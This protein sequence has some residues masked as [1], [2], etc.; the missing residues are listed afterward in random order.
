MKT[1]DTQRL[2]A[3]FRGEGT[4]HQGRT[5]AQIVS[6]SD[7]WLEKTHDYIQWLFPLEKP[8]NFNPNAPL[9]TEEVRAAFADP[10]QRTLQRNFGAAILRMLVFYGYSVGPLTPNEVSPTSEWEDKA[11]NWLTDGN[12]N[13]M[14]LTR[15][16]RCMTLLGREALAKSLHHALIA[17]AE[18]H[19][20]IVTQRTLDFWNQAVTLNPESL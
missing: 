19:P 12:H 11:A 10:A 15:I 16:L 7:D 14:R 20:D 4:D 6:K 2:L 8:S 5:L 9:L 18:V 1:D 13:Q 17:A 3:F